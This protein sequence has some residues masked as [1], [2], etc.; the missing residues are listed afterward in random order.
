MNFVQLQGR[1]SWSLNREG[2]AGAAD[3]VKEWIK[4]EILH[5]E[6]QAIWPPGP[7]GEAHRWS[8]LLTDHSFTCVAALGAAG[9][10]QALPDDFWMPVRVFTLQPGSTQPVRCD[11]K[12]YAWL[13][14]N[15]LNQAGQMQPYLYAL[16]PKTAGI[17]YFWLAP[18]PDQA[19]AG[20]LTYYK[21][22]SQ[23]TNDEDS[24]EWTQD[25]WSGIHEGA[26]GR[27]V[28]DLKDRQEAQAWFADRDRSLARAISEDRAGA[29]EEDMVLAVSPDANA[30]P[31]RPRPIHDD[32]DD[33]EI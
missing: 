13:Q 5:W 31:G 14:E 1:V 19:Y 9:M 20:T 30:L 11:M 4:D 32:F 12:D 27:G 16:G 24:N 33:R 3:Q 28:R 8:F 6:R 10:R 18:P 22:L 23:L 17:R 15:Y 25:Y 29:L 26:V 21:T 7:V 2:L